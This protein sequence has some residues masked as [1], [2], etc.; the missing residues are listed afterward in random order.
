MEKLEIK[1]K[2]KSQRVRFKL[3]DA[4]G[5]SECLQVCFLCQK[6]LFKVRDKNFESVRLANAKTSLDDTLYFCEKFEIDYDQIRNH[7]LN[8]DG[9]IV[10]SL[11]PGGLVEFEYENQKPS[12]L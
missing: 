8:G 12:L 2:V 4:E 11:F 7:A 1:H 9:G 3:V 6:N 5:Q 10:K